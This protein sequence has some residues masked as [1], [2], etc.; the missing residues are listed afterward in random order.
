M[1]PE[2]EWLEPDG[3]GGFASGTVGRTP[4][5]PLPRAVADR[6]QIERVVLVNGFEAW[7]DVAGATY[8]LST[9][10]YAPDVV[11]PRGIDH[12]V[13]FT[14]DPWPRWTFAL[15]DG[16]VVAH[17]VAVTRAGH[18][19]ADLATHRRA[20]GPRRSTVRPLAVGARAITR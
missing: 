11:H 16:T 17:E 12:L 1:A 5:A 13:A 15:P 9:Q 18:G 19:R 8:P 10:R 2:R 4:H 20:A 6:A 14:T 3:H 7:L